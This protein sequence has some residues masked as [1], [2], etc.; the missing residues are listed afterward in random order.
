MAVPIYFLHPPGKAFR[1]LPPRHQ[2]FFQ[3]AGVIFWKFG[4]TAA[5]FAIM[6]CVIRQNQSDGFR[7]ISVTFTQRMVALKTTRE[8]CLPFETLKS[9]VTDRVPSAKYVFI[10]PPIGGFD[11][12]S[13]LLN[14]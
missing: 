7:D 5:Y 4:I 3:S 13:D 10:L 2:R 12:I 11:H 1:E 8:T 9:C 6:L 14:Y